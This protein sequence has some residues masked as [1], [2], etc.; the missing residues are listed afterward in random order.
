M[1]ASKLGQKSK[2]AGLE[3]GRIQQTEK[4]GDTEVKEGKTVES[5]ELK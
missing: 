2:K 3:K 5:N 1:K 4:A